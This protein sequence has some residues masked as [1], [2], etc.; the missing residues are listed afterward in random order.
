MER[1]QVVVGHVVH[2]HL[3]VKEQLDAVE[4][5]TLCGHVERRQAVLRAGKCQD[6][7][8]ERMKQLAGKNKTVE[9]RE[10]SAP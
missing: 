6:D 9:D 2:G 7:T 10:H 5:V 1:R 8:F 4:V 3:V